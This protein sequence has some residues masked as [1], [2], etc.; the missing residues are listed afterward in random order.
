MNEDR[1]KFEMR[2]EAFLNST[3]WRGADYDA[4]FIDVL[5]EY[6]IRSKY[7][8]RE[9]TR[10]IPYSRD[11]LRILDIGTTAYT[12]F[13]K[14]VYPHY[15]I[16]TLDLHNYMDI[17]CKAMGIPLTICDLD[18]GHIPFEDGCFDVVIFCEV[19]EHLFI[20]PTEILKEIRRVLRERG[21]LITS[22]PNLA[23]LHQRIRLLFGISPLPN[24]DEQMSRFYH[25]HIHEYTKKEIASLL[26]TSGFTIVSA[27]YVRA[28][29][30]KGT[31]I[32][33]LI[34]EVYDPLVFLIPPFRST[35]H[36]TCYR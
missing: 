1:S 30:S 17:P 21:K 32:R 12:L 23:A 3:K 29:G 20:P 13:L 6:A 31:G 8:F 25:G 4:Q 34:R 5:Q 35:I 28:N 24:A 33:R 9:I 11:S 26:R 15:D 10:S 2:F 36:M 7:R 22:V 18:K 27:K 16:L 14:E 19:L